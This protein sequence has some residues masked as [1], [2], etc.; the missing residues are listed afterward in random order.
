MTV[1]SRGSRVRTRWTARRRC[2]SWAQALQLVVEMQNALT[3]GTGRC[4]TGEDSPQELGEERA[5]TS[6]RA[7]PRPTAA[8]W[9]TLQVCS[10]GD[11]L[12]GPLAAL[13]GPV[14]PTEPVSADWKSSSRGLANQGSGTG[15]IAPAGA[16]CIR[17][18]E[19]VR[20]SCRGSGRVS[21]D[22]SG[23]RFRW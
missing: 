15:R 8:F 3:A 12:P 21:S 4:N 10:R 13:P 11:T 19:A 16:K 14:L 6:C 1:R 9:R 18:F 7:L 2:R 22:A 20:L 17:K 23:S 5:P